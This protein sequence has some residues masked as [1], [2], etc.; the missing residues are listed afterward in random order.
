MS[1]NL[2][3]ESWIPIAGIKEKKSLRQV[4]SDESLQRLSG[5][6][7]DKIVI[8]RFLLSIVHASTPLPDFESWQTLTVNQISDNVLTYL[9]QHHDCFDLYGNKPFLQFPQLAELG[10]KAS[11][12]GSMMVNIA[13]GNKVV[14]TEWNQFAGISNAEKPVLL[15]RSSCF[16]CGGK[17]YDPKITLSSGLEKGKTGIGGTLLGAYGLLHVYLLG[18]NLLDSLRINLLTDDEIKEIAAFPAG[19]GIPFWEKMPCG[20]K[21]E[22][23]KEY[24]DSY[25]G[26]LFPMDKFVLF[27]DNGIIKTA[28]IS[29]QTDPLSMRDPALTLVGEEKKQH[30]LNVKTEEHPWRE[31]RALLAFL[32]KDHSCQPYFLSMGL[33]KLRRQSPEILT[34]WA[35]GMAVSS[36][37][38]EQYLS[39]MNDYVES[40]FTFPLS[41]MIP[42]S[43]SRLCDIMECLDLHTKRLYASIASYYKEMNNKERNNELGKLQAA[44]GKTLFWEQ[45]DLRSQKILELAFSDASA[46]EIE[47]E[48]KTDFAILCRIYNEICPNE[49][50]RQMTAWVQNNPGLQYNK[51]QKEKK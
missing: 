20:E 11:A 21:D 30:F 19:K 38:G 4:F 2:C 16:A 27:K 8:F 5:N 10:G 17:K 40:E 36:N 37:S 7:V 9:E 50:P 48:K 35:G 28:G 23:A 47:Q 26:Q 1:Y 24:Q 41:F 18:N 29:Y 3:D 14:L 12:L 44:H 22:R 46:E 6:P 49:T 15:L 32:R 13:E 31:L 42:S 34:V 33:N 25:F 45:M 51:K 39:G 43:L